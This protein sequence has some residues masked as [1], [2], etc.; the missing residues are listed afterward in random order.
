MFASG[1][2]PVDQHNSPLSSLSSRSA[3]PVLNV[4][5][6]GFLKIKAFLKHGVNALTRWAVS[7]TA[8]CM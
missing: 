2:H 5:L 8:V 4:L 7:V 1:E 3:A 6:C